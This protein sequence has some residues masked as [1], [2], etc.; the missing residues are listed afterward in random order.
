MCL[1]EHNEHNAQRYHALFHL[2]SVLSI[3]TSGQRTHERK[4]DTLGSGCHDSLLVA[5]AE[6]CNLT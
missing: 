4:A 3:E 2:G 5:I 6:L 1:H